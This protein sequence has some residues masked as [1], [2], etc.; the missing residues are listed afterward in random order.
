MGSH[1]ANM[2]WQDVVDKIKIQEGSGEEIV[3]ATI[4]LGNKSNQLVLPKAVWQS[5]RPLAVLAS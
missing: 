4:R 5:F 1:R 2:P 3:R